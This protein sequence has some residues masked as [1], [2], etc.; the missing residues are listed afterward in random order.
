MGPKSPESS[1]LKAKYKAKHSGI[2]REARRSGGLN[3]TSLPW[4]GYGYFL[5][6]S[7]AVIVNI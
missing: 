4:G 2:S 3:Q 7:R 1:F 5:E 6:H